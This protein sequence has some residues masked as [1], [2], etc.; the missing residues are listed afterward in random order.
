MSLS[1]ERNDYVIVRDTDGTKKKGRLV[2]V[3]KN[4]KG[5][6]KGILVDKQMGET[7]TVKYVEFG[8]IDVLSVL[9]PNPEYG[10]V[11]GVKVETYHGGGTTKLGNLH[12]WRDLVQGERNRIEKVIKLAAKRVR[13]DKLTF[14]KDVEVTVRHK[15]GNMAGFY[16]HFG[17]KDKED[18]LC[19]CVSDFSK[20]AI[21]FADLQYLFFHEYAHSLW[22]TRMSPEMQGEWIKAYSR[23]ITLS[24]IKTD[25]IEEYRTELI[26]QGRVTNLMKNLD[27]DAKLEFREC[28]RWVKRNH[29][30]K[31]THI[32]ALLADNDDLTAVWPKNKIALQRKEVFISE[33]ALKNPDEF[34]AEAFGYGY[35][36]TKALPKVI[37]KLMERTFKELKADGGGSA[38]DI[39]DDSEL[40]TDD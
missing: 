2:L 7:A 12:Y 5:S 36:K 13:A 30:L 3:K 31:P 9:G 19:L 14:G 37:I 16:K 21:P 15:H 25:S 17:K 38:Q 8:E 39:D 29:N 22:F 27:D 1:V 11:Y 10:T 33:Y 23:N 20:R 40:G 35:S 18:E 34:F 6:C 26:E 28:L 32:N 4:N 24:Q